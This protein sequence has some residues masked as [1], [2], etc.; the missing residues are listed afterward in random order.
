MITERNYR[1]IPE[2]RQM[3]ESAVQAKV[4]AVLDL[5]DAYHQI[6]IDPKYKKYNTTNTL[7]G[8]FTI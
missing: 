2:E 1:S 3:L 6:R 7:F 5:T 4:L 8:C